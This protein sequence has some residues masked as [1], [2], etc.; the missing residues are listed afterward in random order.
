VVTTKKKKPVM[1]AQITNRK[2][3]Q[4]GTGGSSL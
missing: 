2:P 3:S 1:E 4:P